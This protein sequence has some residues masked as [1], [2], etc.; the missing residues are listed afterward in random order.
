M[1]RYILGINDSKIHV[2]HKCHN[3]MDNRKKMLRPTTCH[4][5]TMNEKL[6]VNNTSGVTGVSWEEKSS[7]WHSYIWFNGKTI[8]LGRYIDFEEAVE[9]RKEAEKKVFWRV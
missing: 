4:N 8:H 5:N 9:K 2:D 3:N 7:K 1:H 6:T